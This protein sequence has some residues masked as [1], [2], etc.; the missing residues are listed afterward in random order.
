MPYSEPSRS[1][2]NL[3]DG[4]YTVDTLPI[5]SAEMVDKYARVSDL[6]GEKRDLVLCSQ[7]GSSYFW[8]PV[9]PQYAKNVSLASADVTLTALKSP[10]VL[11]AAGTLAA[12]RSIT[13]SNTMAYPGASFEVGFDG[14]LGLFG[15]AIKNELGSTLAALISGGRK[16]YF[17]ADGSWQ[18]F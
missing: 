6:F 18:T 15:I 13:L 11:L 16:R 4:A 17:F 1:A 5:P 14:A 3:I 9:R 12:N 10:S 7:V 8:Q 2:S